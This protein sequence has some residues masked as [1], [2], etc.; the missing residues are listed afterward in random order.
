MIKVHSFPRWFVEIGEMRALVGAT[1]VKRRHASPVLRDDVKV[2]HP[3]KS[4]FRNFFTTECLE[5]T[6]GLK[7]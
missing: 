6:L 3:L 7:Y 4:L 1:P 2:L 5:S